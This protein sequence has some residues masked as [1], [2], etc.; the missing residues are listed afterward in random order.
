MLKKVLAGSVAFMVGA[1]FAWTGD[2][3]EQKFIGHGWDLLCATPEEILENAEVFDASGLDGVAVSLKGME[4]GKYSWRYAQSTIATDKPWP[5]ELLQSRI[6]T[7][8]KYKDHP[9]LRDSLLIFWIAPVKHLAWDDDAAWARFAGN[10]GTLAWVGKSAGMKGYM[11]DMEDYTDIRQYFWDP[12]RDTMSYDEACKLARKRGAEIFRALFAEHRDAVVISF[13]FMSEAERYYA[14]ARSPLAAARRRNDLWPS[15]VNGI[16]DAFPEEATFVDGNEHGYHGES[17][18]NDFYVKHFNQRQGLLGLVAPENRRK[19]QAMLSVG[20]GQYLDC[21]IYK[22]S[23]SKTWYKG[24]AED[25]SRLTHFERNLEQAARCSSQYVWI[26]GEHRLWIDWK[27]YPGSEIWKT[28]RYVDMMSLP[29]PTWE[30]SLP[31]L[32]DAILSVKNP[33]AFARKK[34]AE[35]RASGESHELCREGDCRLE[36]CADGTI[37]AGRIPWGFSVYRNPGDTVGCCGIDTS[38]G[39]GDRASLAM[40]GVAYCNVN[41]TQPAKEGECYVVSVSTQS[42]KGQAEVCWMKGGTWAWAESEH[43]EFGEPDAEGW[44]TARLVVRVPRGVSKIGLLAQTSKL[45]SDEVVRFD[46]FSMIRLR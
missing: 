19:Y 43:F 29:E 37:N 21:Y 26:Y 35:Y 6:E 41:F 2:V 46:D 27:K 7:L 25:G 28:K 16:I 32:T 24:P 10:V 22:P 42:K 9:G 36:G 1:A 34:L 11:V 5:R 45:E 44:R 4:P 23:D 39:R 15:F 31:G 17:D 3:C 38:V 33:L 13:W 18:N 30:K 20:F 14:H 8:K 12:K 40:K